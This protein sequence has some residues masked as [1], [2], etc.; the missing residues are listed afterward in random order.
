MR[1]NPV[2]I[3]FSPQNVFRVDSLPKGLQRV[4]FMPV[5]GERVQAKEL[6]RLTEVFL[7]ELRRSE[8]FSVVAADSSQQRTSLNR[9]ASLDLNQLSALAD[10]YDVQG[11]LQLEVTHL[12]AY[13]PLLIGVK[14]RLITLDSKKPQ[15]LWA[16][17]SLFDAGQDSVALGA[18][19][20]AQD[21]NQQV[22]PLSSSYTSL[23]VP[24]RF[25]A[26]VA[27]SIFK[28]LPKI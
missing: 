3:P 24:S 14:A 23:N 5:N 10:A 9:G 15:V 16:L 4:L 28:T 6:A 22:F 21:Y 17:D 20:H 2:G 27:N 8:R 25:A 11:V 19:M 7:S 1:D 12:R 26:Y 13:K 18:R